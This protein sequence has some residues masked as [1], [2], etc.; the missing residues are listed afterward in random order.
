MRLSSIA[1][2]VVL[3]IVATSV[4]PKSA[5][6]A[7]PLLK[8]TDL[9]VKSVKLISPTSLLATF[10]LAGQLVGKNFT[11][12]NLTVPISFVQTG[13]TTHIDPLTGAT[14]TCPILHLE[15][16]IEYLN[17]LGLV[18]ELN[19]CHEGPITVDIT[20]DQ[21]GGLLGDLLCGLLGPNGL[22]NLNLAN[23]ANLEDLVQQV[24]NHIFDEL[25]GNGTPA[26]PPNTGGS[27]QASPFACPVLTLELGAI[28]LDLLG[29]VVETSDICLFVYAE[30]N[31]GLLGDL[32]CQLTDAFNGGASQRA[33][34]ALAKQI[35]SIITK[36]GL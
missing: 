13:V 36:R 34:D 2:A 23:I 17:I 5:D 35:I 4:T 6:A 21:G 20:A 32:L 12:H 31:Q 9:N 15:L 3:A 16:E 8:V 25:T 27:N 28:T 33:L 7:A 14:E 1:G 30:P 22:L 18:V 11:L 19:N 26:N 24:L 29:L 10:D